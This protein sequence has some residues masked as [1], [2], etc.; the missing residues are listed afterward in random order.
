MK[1]VYVI[2]NI[3]NISNLEDVNSN[4]VIY[5]LDNRLDTKITNNSLKIKN[6]I[7]LVSNLEILTIKDSV[8]KL[9]IKWYDD[10]DIKEFLLIN[11]INLGF[12][13]ELELFTFLV[14]L[15]TDIKI[16]EK[17]IGIEKP[18]KIIAIGGIEYAE[19]VSKKYNLKYES[20]SNVETARVF[21]MDKIPIKYDF[22]N[23]PVGFTLSIEKYNSLREKFE[24]FTNI[25]LKKFQNRIKNEGDYL[26][27]EFN[28]AIFYDL[29]QSATKNHQKLNFLNLRRPAIWNINSF[30]QLLKTN[31]EVITSKDFMKNKKMINSQITKL[32]NNL[33]ELFQKENKLRDLFMIENESYWPIIKIYINKFLKTRGIQAVKEINMAINLFESKNF[34]VVLGLNDNLQTEKT[35]ISIANQKGI[36]TIILQHGMFSHVF[37]KDAPY[38]RINAVL[39]LVAKYNVVWGKIDYEYAINQGWNTE[40]VRMIGGPKF[41]SQF[42]KNHYKKRT[43]RILLATTSGA[44]QDNLMYQRYKES[45]K[46]T[47]EIVKD[48]ENYELIIK[49]HPVDA[50]LLM[51]KKIVNEINPSIPIM[52]NTNLDELIESSDLV[53]T[54]DLSTVILHALIAQKPIIVISDGENEIQDEPIFQYDGLVLIQYEKLE[55]EIKK[56]ITDSKLREKLIINGKNLTNDCFSNQGNASEKLLEFMKQL[57]K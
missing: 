19:H 47:I 29:I 46:K 28:P 44:T 53:I 20:K 48:L 33:E 13:V 32:E 45:I 27:L 5:N 57:K 52:M 17:I 55:Q 8:L 3:K 1:C 41:D 49:L 11:Q 34:D 39:P 50:N 26:L 56:I 9:V 23:R 10:E 24:K 16:L 43:K 7:N 35:I 40:Q 2:K 21:F 38:V 4:D 22:F 54:F 15:I 30:K 31:S 12:L 6:T 36:P 51:I 42:K 14:K 18:D 37:K 25:I